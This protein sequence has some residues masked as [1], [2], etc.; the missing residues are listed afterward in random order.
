V[1]LDVLKKP[2]EYCD[3]CM[4]SGFE[5]VQLEDDQEAIGFGWKT[6]T[7][8]SARFKMRLCRCVTC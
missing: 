3:D 5:I 4:G 1:N 7:I 6:L 2:Y 8:G